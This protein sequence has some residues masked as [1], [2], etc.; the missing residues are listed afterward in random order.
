MGTKRPKQNAQNQTHNATKRAM[1]QN[2]RLQN[3]QCY[4]KV[5]ILYENKTLM[6]DFLKKIRN[7]SVVV[8]QISGVS[9]FVI[10]RFVALGVLWHYAFCCIWR[11][12]FGRF[13]IERFV[14][15]P[16]KLEV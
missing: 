8:S 10:E 11:F 6:Y 4:K 16:S 2:A 5:K 1:Q 3:V 14:S 13:V 15:I 9:R 7:F 12:V